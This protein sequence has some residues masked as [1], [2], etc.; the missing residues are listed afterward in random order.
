MDRNRVAESIGMRWRDRSEYAFSQGILFPMSDHPPS[1]VS[2]EDVEDDI[3]VEIGPLD[4][5][6]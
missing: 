5:P 2:T 3:E 1:D 4:W 6:F